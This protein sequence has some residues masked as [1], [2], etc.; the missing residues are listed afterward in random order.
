MIIIRKCPECGQSFDVPEGMEQIKC[1]EC[2]GLKTKDEEYKAIELEQQRKG[3][4][5]TAETKPNPITA[6]DIL[7]AKIFGKNKPS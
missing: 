4:E 2:L 6:E 5:K 1:P 7:I 3:V